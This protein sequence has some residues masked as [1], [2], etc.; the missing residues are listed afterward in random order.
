MK[1]IF[2]YATWCPHCQQFINDGLSNYKDMLKKE[3]VH[4]KMIESNESSELKKVKNKYNIEPQYF[5]SFFLIDDNKNVHEVTADDT[6]NNIQLYRGTEYMKNKTIHNGR[7]GEILNDNKPYKLVLIYSE[8]DNHTVIKKIYSQFSDIISRCSKYS[9]AKVNVNKL[10]NK[11]KYQ[12]LTPFFIII[13]NTKDKSKIY[14]FNENDLKHLHYHIMK[15][16]DKNYFIKT[17][18]TLEHNNI[19]DK[20]NKKNK[21]DDNGLLHIITDY[22][23]QMFNNDFKK[24]VGE[25]QKIL[26]CSYAYDKNGERVQTCSEI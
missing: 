23:S 15:D 26:K 7:N 11:H 25:K 2:I 22:F 3:N 17:E 20:N 1:V 12:A 21:K 8:K 16:E 19:Y 6:L 18:K 5:P 9:I 10:K 4:F 13:D 24:D 14:A